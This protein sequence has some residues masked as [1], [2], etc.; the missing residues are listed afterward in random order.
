MKDL[1][2][3][4]KTGKERLQELGISPTCNWFSHKRSRHYY[5]FYFNANSSY[6]LESDM[7]FLLQNTGTYG[8]RNARWVKA[9]ALKRNWIQ[10]GD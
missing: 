9:T 8:G 3:N 7:F 2:L 5:Q 4:Q 1:K 10:E 6:D